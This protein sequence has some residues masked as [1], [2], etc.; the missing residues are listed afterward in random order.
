MVKNNHFGKPFHVFCT[1]IYVKFKIYE[2]LCEEAF[3]LKVGALNRLLVNTSSILDVLQKEK[4]SDS[5]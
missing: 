1:L 3:N 5:V 4:H 2:L